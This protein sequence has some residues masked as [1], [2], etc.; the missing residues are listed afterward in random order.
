MPRGNRVL[1]KGAVAKNRNQVPAAD[2]ASFDM[3][4]VSVMREQIRSTPGNMSAAGTKFELYTR[5]KSANYQ[6]YNIPVPIPAA[7]AL[8]VSNFFKV[9]RRSL[10]IL[11]NLLICR[12]P[13]NLLLI[14]ETFRLSCFFSPGMTT[15]WQTSGTWP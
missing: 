11:I 1:G 12:L 4:Y 9:V 7:P 6:L 8:A 3:A 14:C 15:A 10:L 13:R 5:L 2:L